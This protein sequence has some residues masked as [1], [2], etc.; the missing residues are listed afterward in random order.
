MYEPVDV[1][2]AGGPG[3]ALHGLRHPVL[4][5]PVGLPAR[6]PHTGLERPR[7]PGPL[8]RR[9]RT[10]A[11]HQQLPRVHGPDVPGAVRERL[12]AVHKR[13]ARHHKGRSR[14]R[15]STTAGSTAGSRR[16][17]RAC[18]TGKTGGRGGLGAGGH[19][20]RPAADPGRPRG[21]RLRARRPPRR[22][23]PLRHPGLQDGQGPPGP[24][25]RRRCRPRAPS[26]SAASTSASTCRS[27]TCGPATTP[28]SW[29]SAPCG[30]RDLD[31]PGRHLDGVHLAMDYLVP[32][33]RVQAGL[34]ARPPSTPPA[35]R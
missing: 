22:P 13:P 23:D 1:R 32:S 28:W 4:Q 2:R 10:P 33:N 18:K 6:Q 5:Q 3:V 17:A 35:R 16:C 20:G 12:R 21:R 8:A 19:G 34:L 29:P 25:G 7:L 9:H 24:P 27:R 31:I 11:R 15:S 14:R 30:R 26:S